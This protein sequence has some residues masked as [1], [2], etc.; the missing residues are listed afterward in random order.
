MAVGGDVY[1]GDL[2]NVIPSLGTIE[3]GVMA[4]PFTIFAGVGVINAFNMSDGVDGLCGTL[5]LVALSGLGVAAAMADR[6][7]ELFLI[8]A[9]SGGLIG[10]LIFNVRVPGRSQAKAFLGDAGSYLL[11]LA[12]LYLAVRLSQG[13]GRAMPPVAALWFCL[14]PLV[15]TVGMIL[16][17]VRRGRS[18]FSPDREHI[19]HVFLLAKFSVSETWVGLTGVALIGMAFGLSGMINRM[20]ESIMLATFLLVGVLYYG[21]IMRAWRVMKFLSRSINR[22]AEAR[23]DRRSGSDRRQLDTTYFVNGVPMDRRSGEDRR[24]RDRRNEDDELPANVTVITRRKESKSPGS[25][26]ARMS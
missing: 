25:R 5:A 16:R 19:H 24:Q 6:V 13:E 2:G 15:D 22:R 21:L 18:P 20:P 26:A 14:L 11:G 1:V 8:A 10:F 7:G 17:R 12:V 9:L 23:V 3:L 4:L